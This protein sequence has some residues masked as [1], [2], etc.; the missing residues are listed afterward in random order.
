M[1]ALRNRRIRLICSTN[2][3]TARHYGRVPKVSGALKTVNVFACSA[4]TG[5][6][7]MADDPVPITATRLPVKSTPSFGHN[8]V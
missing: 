2:L 3:A 8:P 6:D 1:V 7:W 5:M 4:I